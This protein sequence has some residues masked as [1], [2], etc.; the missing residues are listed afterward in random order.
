MAHDPHNQL[1]FGLKP[2]VR[3]FKHQIV[4]NNQQI[5]MYTTLM[6]WIWRITNESTVEKGREYFL[7][8]NP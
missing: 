7:P 3:Y 5:V 8:P 1:Q 6:K 2:Y 4:D